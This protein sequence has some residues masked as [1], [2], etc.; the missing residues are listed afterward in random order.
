MIVPGG[1]RTVCERFQGKRGFPGNFVCASF[2]ACDRFSGNI[3]KLCDF[4]LGAN[5]AAQFSVFLGGHFR[6]WSSK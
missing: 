3:E 4:G 6:A 1:R 5:L 2:S